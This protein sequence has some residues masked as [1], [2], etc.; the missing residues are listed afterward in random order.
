MRKGKDGKFWH[1]AKFFS[2]PRLENL[3]RE[4]VSDGEAPAAMSFSDRSA[5]LLFLGGAAA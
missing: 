4:N 3:K 1:I 5:V 2:P